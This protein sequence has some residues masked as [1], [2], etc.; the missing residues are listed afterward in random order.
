[1][2]ANSSSNKINQP[3]KAAHTFGISCSFEHGQ[4][5]SKREQISAHDLIRFATEHCRL[6]GEGLD[7][8]R[9]IYQ[10]ASVLTG[11]GLS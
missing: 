8:K 1:M 9:L 4:N 6:K 3:V 2:K 7:L 11:E 5:Q 10:S